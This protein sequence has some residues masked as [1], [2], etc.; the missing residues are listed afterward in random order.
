MLEQYG[1]L[2]LMFLMYIGVFSVIFYPFQLGLVYLLVA[3][4]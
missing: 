4:S 3:I 1:F 2:I